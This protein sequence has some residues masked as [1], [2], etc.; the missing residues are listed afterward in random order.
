MLS[1]FSNIFS[2]IRIAWKL[3]EVDFF[4][5]FLNLLQCNLFCHSK[6]AL[7]FS[8]LTCNLLNN[9]NDHYRKLLLLGYYSVCL[10]PWSS[11]ITFWSPA[12]TN[13]TVW[14]HTITK[15]VRH[16]ERTNVRNSYSYLVLMMQWS[17]TTQISSN[18]DNLSKVGSQFSIW[19]LNTRYVP[20]KIM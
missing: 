15:L 8:S 1:A 3:F 20:W 19:F 10:Q 13:F 9:V 12:L 5:C 18:V 2:I 4:W 17:K 6:T 11:Q 7:G 14:E 16:D